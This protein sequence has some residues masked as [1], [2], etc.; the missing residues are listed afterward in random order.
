MVL[1]GP[2]RPSQPPS[3]LHPL[4]SAVA[5][6]ISQRR[7]TS[8]GTGMPSPPVD[9]GF[10][11]SQLPTEAAGGGHPCP[12]LPVSRD[13]ARPRDGR[14]VF[15]V[16]AAPIGAGGWRGLLGSKREHPPRA[17]GEQ[18]RETAPQGHDEGDAG[19]VGLTR[20][21]TFGMERQWKGI[22]W[23]GRDC[24]GRKSPAYWQGTRRAALA[25]HCRR[26]GPGGRRCF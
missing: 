1:Y 13:R 18:P 10:L 14:E 8:S 5:P 15:V 25:L 20:A 3:P 2:D 24:P 26:V 11:R 21:D 6:P 19:K 23:K 9:Q 22:G 4:V 12:W 7:A 17:G 16:P